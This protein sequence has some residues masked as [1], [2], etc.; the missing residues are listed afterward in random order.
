MPLHKT[1]N[2]NSS[3]QILVWKITE[4]YEDLFD[5][6]VLN[7]CSRLRLGGM[8]SELHQRGFLSVRKLL[9][10]AS[11]NDF[12]L[13]YDE[14]G[15][16]HLKDGKHI[17]ITHSYQFSAIIISDQTVGIDIELQ[18]EK[19]I[20]IAS[21]FN[22]DDYHFLKPDKK[23]EYIRKLTVIWGAKES[24]FK[25]RNERGIS[26][27]EHI[28]VHAFEMEDTLAL[29][30]LHFDATVKGFEIYFEEIENFS[31]VYACEKR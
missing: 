12:D 13:S 15:K 18:R 31:L 21:K 25:I 7:E 1:I 23:E 24:I 30:E 20:K 28:K 11:Y 17:S 6:V 26:F 8:K 10:E 5:K 22:D 29:A 2:F 4:S 3:T 9:Q 14:L 16:P 27:K 19:I